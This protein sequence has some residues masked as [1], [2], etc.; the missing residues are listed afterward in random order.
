[1]CSFYALRYSTLLSQETLSSGGDIGFKSLEFETI[2]E[3]AISKIQ[4]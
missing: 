1:M 3:Q 4:A 2:R